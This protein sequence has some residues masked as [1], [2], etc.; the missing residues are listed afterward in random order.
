MVGKMHELVDEVRLV[1]IVS[2]RAQLFIRRQ[3]LAVWRLTERTCFEHLRAAFHF[4][5][6]LFSCVTRTKVVN[7]RISD[8]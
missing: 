5:S 7:K 1:Q 6:R 3:V 4:L 2:D 8:Y